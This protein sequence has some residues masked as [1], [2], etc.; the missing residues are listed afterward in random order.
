MCNRSPYR[1]GLSM[2]KL[3]IFFKHE[4]MR[5]YLFPKLIAKLKPDKLLQTFFVHPKKMVD[6][7]NYCLLRILVRSW[8]CI[9][10]V[11]LFLI[12]PLPYSP[13]KNYLLNLERISFILRKKEES[14]DCRKPQGVV[15][16]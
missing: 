6:T 13:S 1:F 10:F 8:F 3:T 7:V 11:L 12:T 15:S 2:N 9:I 5:L 16:F 14:G 4:P